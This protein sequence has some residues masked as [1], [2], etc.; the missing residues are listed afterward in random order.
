MSDQNWRM[1][2]G[3]GVEFALKGLSSVVH[4]MPNHTFTVGGGGGGGGTP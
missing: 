2:S 4:C 1:W 3:R